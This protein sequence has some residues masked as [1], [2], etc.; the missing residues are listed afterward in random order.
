MNNKILK[1]NSNIGVATFYNQ[2]NLLIASFHLSIRFYFKWFSE[3][4]NSSVQ[5]NFDNVYFIKKLNH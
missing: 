2:V 5:P 1:S 4:S 3:H